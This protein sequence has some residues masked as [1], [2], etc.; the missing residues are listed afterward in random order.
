MTRR[1]LNGANVVAVLEQVR[2]KRVPK[3]VGASPRMMTRPP[4]P[5]PTS[6]RPRLSSPTCSR[7]WIVDRAVQGGDE[8]GAAQRQVFDAAGRV[9]H[10]ASERGRIERAVA[11]IITGRSRSQDRPCIVSE[12]PVTSMSQIMTHARL[13][14]QILVERAG[15]RSTSAGEVLAARDVDGERHPREM[16]RCKMI[17][18]AEPFDPGM[19]AARAER[20]VGDVDRSP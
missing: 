10:I 7:S 5:T 4:V 20:T 13:S 3:R 9:D 6:R 15:L 18:L 12:T 1:L 19:K 11:T 16:Q 8:H 17:P 14:P 2:R